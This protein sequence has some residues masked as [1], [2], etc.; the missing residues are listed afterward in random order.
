MLSPRQNTDNK[1]DYKHIMELSNK[2]ILC[3]HAI[4]LKTDFLSDYVNTIFPTTVTNDV[5]INNYCI[6]HN[7][8]IGVTKRAVVFQNKTEHESLNGTPDFFLT[9][10][11]YDFT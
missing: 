1:D 6:K 8:R 7:K 9:N 10:Q 2:R 11:T 5:D 4:V 3:N